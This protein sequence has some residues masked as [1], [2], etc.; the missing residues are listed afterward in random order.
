MKVLFLKSLIHPQIVE[1]VQT[2]IYLC[3]YECTLNQI[4]LKSA[5]F[6]RININ[7]ADLMCLLTESMVF[8]FPR[9]IESLY[10]E[11]VEEGLLIQA[12]KVNLSDY[13]GKAHQQWCMCVSHTCVTSW[14][15]RTQQRE[16]HFICVLSR[17]WPLVACSKCLMDGIGLSSS[18]AGI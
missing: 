15:L 17:I 10:K 8:F 4:W 16:A 5:T 14:G 3:T 9:T 12:L 18:C 6:V 2:S 11:L 1:M 7:A 13:I